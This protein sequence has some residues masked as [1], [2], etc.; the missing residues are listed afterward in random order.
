M[1]KD[2]LYGNVMPGPL[3]PVATG[4]PRAD[5]AI[6]ALQAWPMSPY[7]PTARPSDKAY[8][9]TVRRAEKIG[10]ERLVALLD[11]A[12]LKIGVSRWSDAHLSS[13]GTAD[14]KLYKKHYEAVLAAMAV[15][16]AYVHW[17]VGA[18]CNTP[19]GLRRALEV[20]T[21]GSSEARLVAAD[22]LWRHLQGESAKLEVARALEL[23]GWDG[24][25]RELERVYRSGVAMLGQIDPRGAFEHY[26]E[27]LSAPALRRPGGHARAEALLF[28]LLATETP[29]PRWT[30]AV[31]PLLRT[32]HDNLAIMLLE[33]LPPDPSAVEP[34]CVYLPKPDATRGYWH[35]GAVNALARVAD[36]R[37]LPWLVGALNSSWM[38][39]PAAFEGFR[40]AGDPA[41]AHVIRGWLKDNGA[42]DRVRVGNQ[43]IAELEARG[44]APGPEPRAPA[45]P[46]AP[47][48]KRPVLKYRKARAFAAPRLDSLATQTRVYREAFESAGL[49]RYFDRLARR[50]VWMIPTRVDEA[51]LA[52]GGTKLGG[53]PDLPARTEWPRVDG[54]PLTFLAQIALREAA[55]HLPRG[56]L[57]ASGLLSFFVGNDPEGPAGYCERARVI[58][59]PARAKLVR[60]EVPDDFVDQIYQAATVKFHAALRLPSPSN[61]RVTRL[62]KGDELRRYEEEVFDD[63]PAL[64]QLLGHR[65]HGYDAEVPATAQLLLQLTGDSQTG[66]QF[67]DCDLLAFYIDEELLARRE[68]GEVWPKIGD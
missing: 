53:H 33:K 36:Q 1:G 11:D 18:V 28:G 32:R 7:V 41:M 35:T 22:S 49:G 37:A 15:R 3:S 50:A 19:A 2:I 61:Q 20:V 52:I 60:R 34:L 55:P 62:L 21:K 13:L 14:R 30:A 59:T 5:E 56:L 45:R 38:N 27:L 39:W 68:F 9:A 47:S 42:P 67:G 12:A 31:L 43:V 6:R 65:N 40:R 64:P 24:K 54:E 8:A 63:S 26:H 10:A 66:M 16:K 25:A 17:L 48:P 46:P 23:R 57:P 4:D 44:A 58:F 51:R 29:D